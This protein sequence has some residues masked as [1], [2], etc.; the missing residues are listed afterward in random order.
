MLAV[1]LY[2][3]VVNKPAGIPDVW[4]AEVRE[5]TELPSPDW[6]AMSLAEFEAYKTTH[7]A[8]YNT[9]YASTLPPPDPSAVYLGIVKKTREFGESLMDSSAADNIRFGIT[10]A[11]KT[12][13]IGDAVRD[14]VYYLR[15][16]SLYEAMTAID[17]IVIT[18]EMAPFITAENLVLFKN[19]IRAYLGLPPL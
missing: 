9:W 7:Q 15:S 12:K 19:K 10:Q 18:P 11:G 17:A 1:L 2:E 14:V 13:L 6:V 4:P 5:V 3:K 16:G 8:T